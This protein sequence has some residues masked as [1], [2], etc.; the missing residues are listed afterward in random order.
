MYHGMLS[1]MKVLFLLVPIIIYFCKNV[2]PTPLPL[3]SVLSLTVL[4]L[5]TVSDSSQ[6]DMPAV[7]ATE[8]PIPTA[9]IY[10]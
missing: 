2:Y 8:Q 4:Q 7:S 5:T 6:D 1:L 3:Q 10:K 9:V